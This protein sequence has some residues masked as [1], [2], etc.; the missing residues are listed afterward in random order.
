MVCIARLAL[1]T[2]LLLAAASPL[3]Y[4]DPP[5][6]DAGVD[7]AARRSQ[8]DA[9]GNGVE[10]T[11]G[12]LEDALTQQGPLARLRYRTPDDLK[13]LVRT[14]VKT[15]LLAAEAK[16]RG[17]EDHSTVQKTVKESAAQAL[18]R[19]EV[20]DKVTPQ[21][22][23]LEEVRAYYD[24][25]AAEFHRVAMRRASII[26]FD[27]LE[28]AKRVLPLAV[29]ADARGFADLAKQHSKHVESKEHGGDLGYFAQRPD[30]DGGSTNVV[31]AVRAAAFQLKQVG[32]TAEAPVVVGTQHVIVRL[33]GD[34]PERHASLDDAAPSIR[35]KLWRERR[36][37][38]LDSLVSK[39]RARDKPAVFSDRVQLISFEDM[40]KRPSGFAPDPEPLAATADAGEKAPR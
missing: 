6:A 24:A 8:V 3:A 9:R 33:T 1:C 10:V 34:R 13:G 16:K 11:L 4:A 12:E 29:K 28:E 14:L 19:Q 27:N 15:E 2:V 26:A 40:E 17:Y 31:E 7:D 35:A 23:P 20:E 30:D 21:S 25:H 22:I 18:V 5:V 37:K 32:D 38:A 39:L 36:Q